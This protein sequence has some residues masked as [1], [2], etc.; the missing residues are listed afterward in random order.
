LELILL[1]DE[2][3]LTNLPEQL[4]DLTV[5]NF[6][7]QQVHNFASL[8]KPNDLLILLTEDNNNLWGLS[9]AGIHPEAL[10]RLQED[11]SLIV[12]HFPKDFSY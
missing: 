2:D 4:T 5:T 9:I 12:F 7:H 6:S 8:I 3:E 1:K 11:L 10:A